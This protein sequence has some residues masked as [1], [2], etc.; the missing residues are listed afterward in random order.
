MEESSPMLIFPR[1]NR[2][3]HSISCGVQLTCQFFMT[4][5]ILFMTFSRE[6]TFSFVDTGFA[7][8]T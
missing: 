3:E 7:D 4:F 1:G 2:P 6:A 8:V 5:S